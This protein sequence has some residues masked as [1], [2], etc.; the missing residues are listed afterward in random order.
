MVAEIDLQQ[1]VALLRADIESLR[2]RLQTFEVQGL[3]ELRL[4]TLFPRTSV[5]GSRGGN[6]AVASLLTALEAQG[7][8]VDGTS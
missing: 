3:Q 7:Y 5:T 4:R 8:I 1:E 2:A 6:A